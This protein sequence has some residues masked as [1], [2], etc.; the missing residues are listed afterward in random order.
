MYLGKLKVCKA[1]IIAGDNLV[2]WPQPR[3]PCHTAHLHTLH[4]DS[5]LL[6][7]AFTYAAGGKGGF[8]SMRSASVIYSENS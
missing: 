1:N 3:A 2:P 4:E 8:V 7:R 5:R 6:R